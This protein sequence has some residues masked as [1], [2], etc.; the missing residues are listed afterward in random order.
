[1]I[2]AFGDMQWIFSVFFFSCIK[3]IICE[4]ITY[5]TYMKLAIIKQD[6]SWKDKILLQARQKSIIF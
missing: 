2:N 6:L 5:I 4:E 3:N 1:M